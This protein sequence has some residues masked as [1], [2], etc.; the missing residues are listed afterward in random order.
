M[1]AIAHEALAASS[2]D[3]MSV[4][5]HHIATGTTRVIGNHV[6]LTNSGDTLTIE[7]TTRF[8]TRNEARIAF[9][10]IDTASIR[11]AVAHC[12]RLA[13]EAGGDAVLTPSSMPIRPRKFGRSTVWCE[14]TATAMIE[15]RQVIVPA[16]LQPVRDAKF[17]VSAFVGTYAHIQMYADKQGLFS[18]GRETDAELTVT[19]WAP[20]EAGVIGSPGWAGQAARDW[21]TLDPT[22]VGAEAARLAALARN[23]VVLE[24]GRRLAILGRPAVAQMVRAIGSNFN[25]IPTHLG[26]TPLSGI[27]I[28]QKIVDERINLSS[29]PN[30]TEGGYL[31]MSDNG[32]PLT[33]MT[34]LREGRLA[35]LAYDPY[36]AAQSSIP[37]SNDPPKALRLQAVGGTITSVDEMI[38]NAVEAIYVN[39]VTDIEIL[40]G[41]SGLMTGVTQGGCFLVHHGKID[42]AVKDFRFAESLYF[43]LNR[44]VAIGS[45]E[46]TAFGYSPWHG[47]WPVAPTI[48]PPLMVR[49]FNFVALA[50]AV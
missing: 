12:E 3:T 33:A 9:N 24:P 36:Y 49:D 39:R 2:A 44:L 42:K 17:N 15:A 7:V 26:Q 50:D 19:G 1:R 21:K 35:N 30:D 46:R 8:G 29:D 48:V 27:K 47:E 16:L 38:A 20:R 25:A 5:V 45:A 37:I 11:A 43:I 6:R 13:H 22:T 4:R 18:M 31:P 28:G 14:D 10:Q 41:R 23:P 34:W 40:D 32:Y